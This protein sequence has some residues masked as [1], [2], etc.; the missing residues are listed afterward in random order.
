[1]TQERMALDSIPRIYVAVQPRQTVEDFHGRWIVANQNADAIR[2]EIAAMLVESNE[3]PDAEW[4]IQDSENFGEVFIEK[5]ESIEAVAAF[6]SLNV[7]HGDL[8]AALVDELGGLSKLDEAKECMESGYRGG[9]YCIEYYAVE[10][11]EDCYGNVFKKLPDWILGRIDYEAVARDLE[12]SG[13]IFTV[14]FDGEIHVFT[15]RVTPRACQSWRV[16]LALVAMDLRRVARL[17]GQGVRQ[18]SFVGL[19]PRR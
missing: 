17:L 5:N 10:F 19:L 8:F 12:T 11:L 4:V 16:S 14:V 7:K 3:S 18:F 2:A 1:M 9:Y 6:A 15:P 13:Y